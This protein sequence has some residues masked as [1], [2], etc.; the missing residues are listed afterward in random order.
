VFRLSV[1]PCRRPW[2]LSQML[3]VQS[4]PFELVQHRGSRGFAGVPG[5]GEFGAGVMVTSVARQVWDWGCAVE[6]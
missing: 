2:I 1:V 4:E 6:A 5:C 3:A